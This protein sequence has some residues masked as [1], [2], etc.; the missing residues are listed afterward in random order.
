MSGLF[1]L[2]KALF[3]TQRPKHCTIRGSN[4]FIIQ[5]C[6]NPKH[7]AAQATKFGPMVSNIGGSSVWKGFLLG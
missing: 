6:I 5:K 7:Q 4:C 2:L 3:T 1:T